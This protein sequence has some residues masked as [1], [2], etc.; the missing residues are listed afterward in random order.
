MARGVERP[1]LGGTWTAGNGREFG[2]PM[3]AQPAAC[4]LRLDLFRL[5]QKFA[6]VA[7]FLPAEGI[8]SQLLCRGNQGDS[9]HEGAR[10]SHDL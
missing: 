10:R 2:L 4:G 3:A 1:R 5:Q 8:C 7:V 6:E 9:S